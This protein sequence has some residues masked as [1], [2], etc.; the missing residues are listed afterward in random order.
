MFIVIDEKGNQHI[1]TDD[2]VGT[3]LHK[4]ID[5]ELEGWWGRWFLQAQLLSG[6]W[7]IRKVSVR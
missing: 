4:T 7:D 1:C 5:G 6:K 3:I 2:G